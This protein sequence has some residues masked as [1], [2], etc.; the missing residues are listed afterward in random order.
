MSWSRRYDDD[1]EQLRRRIRDLEYAA[2]EQREAANRERERQDR[3]TEQR[4]RE[5]REA[6]QEREHTAESWEVA[7]GK[8][9]H[10]FAREVSREARDNAEMAADPEWQASSHDHWF[11]DALAQLDQVEA[12]F[13]ATRNEF[14]AQREVLEQQL[15]DLEQEMRGVMVERVRALPGGDKTAFADAMEDDDPSSWLNW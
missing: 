12:I 3:E 13:K 10:L 11:A 1:P 15:R 6:Q 9:R 5:Y 8:Q 14:Q 4:R 2:E 7:V